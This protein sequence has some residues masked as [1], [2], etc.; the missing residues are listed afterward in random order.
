MRYVG[1]YKLRYVAVS[2]IIHGRYH[3]KL[4]DTLHDRT[5][6]HKICKDRESMQNTYS[7]YTDEA[8]R[9]NEDW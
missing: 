9:R 7:Q 8:R 2:M 3:V 4:V 6:K 1:S 5:I